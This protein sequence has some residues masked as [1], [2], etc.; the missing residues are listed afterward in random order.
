MKRYRTKNYIWEEILSFFSHVIQGKACGHSLS[1]NS[2]KKRK[3]VMPRR[4]IASRNRISLCPSLYTLYCILKREEIF[5]EFSSAFPPV[6]P[7]RAYW[8]I[9]GII[10]FPPFPAAF[11]ASFF[12]F[13]IDSY[14]FL[15]FFVSFF[16]F[17]AFFNH[18]FCNLL[19]LMHF[20]HLSPISRILY[21]L[22]CF[23]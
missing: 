11:L 7:P 5:D 22:F 14:N 18:Y 16:N 8:K 20:W 17:P 2:K 23:P 3:K 6:I 13:S 21:F 10:S 19:A 15:A 9:F 12:Q 4:E 1:L